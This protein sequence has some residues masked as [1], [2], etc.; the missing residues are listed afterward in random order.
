[1]KRHRLIIASEYWVRFL[2]LLYPRDFRDEMG[3]A[4][5]ETYRD[6]ARDALNRGGILHLAAVWVRALLD[7]LRNGPGERAQPAASWRRGGNWGRDVELVSRR[8]VR[9]PAFAAT[10]IGTLTIGLGMF[11]VVY[12]AVQKVLID[13]MPYTDPGDLYYVWRDY[14]PITDLKRGALSGPDIAEL[15]KP[16]DVIEDAVGLQRFLGG[17]FSVREGGD[18]MEIAVTRTTPNLFDVLGV[19]P[20]LGR[21]FAPD[22]AGPGREQVIVLTHGLWNRLGADPGIVGTDV[23]LQGRPFRV[24]GV[25][26]PEYTFVRNE[27]AGPPQAVDAYIPFAVHLAETNARNGAFTGLIRARRDASPGAVAAAVDAAGRA[28]DARDFNGR[29]LK[30]Y[31][32][33]LKAD[34]VSRI[35][36]ALVVLGAAALLLVFM[37]MVNL[38]SLLLARVAQRERELAVSRALGA[39]TIAIVRSALLEG[40]LLGAAGGALG[41]LAAIWGTR[42]LVA[43]APLDLPRRD[44]IA[45]DWR[46]AATVI[47]VGGLLGVLAAAV[48]AAWSARTSLSSLLAGSAVRGGGGHGRLRRGMIVAQ[49]ALSLVLLSS[50]ALVVRSFDRL[51]RT[52][53]GFRADGVFTIRL[54]RPPEFFPQWKDALAFQDRVQNA[55]A[56]IPGVTGASAASTLP[57][58]PTPTQGIIK[59]PGAPG[60]TGDA[61]RDAVLTDIVGVAANYVE[62]MGM[63][64]LAGRTFAE[65]RPDGVREAMIDAVLARRFYPDGSAVGAKIPV[66]DGSLTIIGVVNQA[67]LYDLHADGRPQILVRVEDFGNRALSFVMRTTREPR[68]LLPDVRAAVRGIDPR[69]PVA[70]ARSM[71]EI[72]E[73]ALSQQRTSAALI[74]AFAV[75]ALLLAAM[76]L[77]GVVSGSVTRR[78]HELGLRLAVG[79]DHGRLIRLV[80][81]EGAVLVG[82]G[83]L[84]GAP[85]IYVVGDL[86]RGVLAGV[87]PTDPLTLAAVALGLGIVTMGA[88]YV[89]ARRVLAIDPA[90]VL[91]EE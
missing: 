59:I 13:P 85:G 45:I 69:V 2:L 76:G 90:Q 66:G 72:V 9:A 86:I 5:A 91:R 17:I 20:A 18:P 36:P 78:R 55:L 33:G 63:Q 40:G 11:A 14:G 42:A 27:P 12:T 64:V 67:R 61:E 75:G 24:I 62:V 46:V 53:P 48:P 32:V 19:T 71:G 89:P 58:T 35:R 30:L 65:S 70:D 81:G 79:A 56:A 10:T 6:R 68:S 23:R 44:A 7:S 51:L 31:P 84:I 15:Q 28:I 34:V 83:V 49:V 37:L 16:N 4:V 8:L 25:L 52:D 74:S 80:I 38:S 77:F 88:C 21:G 41:T 3:D 57:L 50:G 60:N 39:N 87:S 29:G 22:E 43:V 26:P 1:M 73:Q 47:A 54:R 82:L